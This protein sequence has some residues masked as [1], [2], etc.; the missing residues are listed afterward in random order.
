MRLKWLNL[1]RCNLFLVK[2]VKKVLFVREGV[3]FFFGLL[4]NYFLFWLLFW[5]F[6][7]YR[8]FEI[9]LVGYRYKILIK[10][11]FLI[12]KYWVNNYF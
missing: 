5:L 12:D 9:G 3:L 11:S 6:L 4:Y 8:K 1:I 7:I 2:I 10:I